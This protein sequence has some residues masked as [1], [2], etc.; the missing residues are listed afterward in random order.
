MIKLKAITLISCL[1]LLVVSCD[2]GGSVRKYKEKETPIASQS[3]TMK[4]DAAA[5]GT[6]A[7]AAPHFKW[8]SPE[9]WTEEKKGSGFRL[10]TFTLKAEDKE[11][12]CTIIPLQG[13]AGGLKANVTRWLGQV[14][15]GMHG[16]PGPANA[17]K[18]VD[19]LLNAQEKFLTKGQFPALFIDFTGVTPK[20][21]KKAILVTVVT[22]GGNSV[23]IKM[24]GA[25]SLRC[26]WAA[27]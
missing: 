20:D 6:P 3:P 7:A 14:G 4:K 5:P 27:C 2:K 25:K 24:T 12:V 11:A 22:V 13:E 9:G 8:E 10:A 17:E 15:G 23:F 1:L 21:S 18:Q 19:E 16:A 26:S